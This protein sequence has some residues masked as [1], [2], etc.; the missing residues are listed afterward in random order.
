MPAPAQATR[1]QKFVVVEPVATV[2]VAPRSVLRQT[3][4]AEAGKLMIAASRRLGSALSCA[5]HSAPA[6]PVGRVVGATKLA[7]PSVLRSTLPPQVAMNT[8]C[9]PAPSVMCCTQSVAGRV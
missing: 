6:E 5:S 7:P 4:P 3:A 9:G 1:V 8:S 2:Q